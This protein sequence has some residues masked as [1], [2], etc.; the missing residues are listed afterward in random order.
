MA[1]YSVVIITKN[2][3]RDL[4]RCLDSLSGSDDVVVVD[5]G[6]TDETEAVSRARA[7]V[8]FLHRDFDGYGPQKRWA[9]AQARHDWV[10]SLDADEALTGE[11]EAEISRLAA[12][13]FAGV[14]GY[15]IPRSLVF[16]GR[17]FRHG[18]ES[19][20]HVL[21]LFDRRR[22]NFDSAPVHERVVVEGPVRRL[23]GRL[24]HY[25]YRDLDEYFE[26][27]NAY[28]RLAAAKMRA[29]G[30][31]PGAA[32]VVV[33]L[34]FTFLQSYFLHG[35][36]R[37]GF[38]GFVWAWLGATYHAVKYLKAGETPDPD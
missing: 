7:H 5:S 1:P 21:R 18:R 22:G 19:A 32:A 16:M 23:K 34:K 38:P 36:W 27:F 13:D 24:L 20:H 31:V 11:L 28:T 14:A 30:R 35:N 17:R 10:L 26:K 9:V 6:S 37:N 2:E 25:S 8:R 15:E 12:D 29:D 33:K 4:P 3:A